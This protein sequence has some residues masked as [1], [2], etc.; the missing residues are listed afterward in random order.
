M[1]PDGNT[2]N[3]FK[4]NMMFRKLFLT[5]VLPFFAHCPPPL[6]HPWCSELCFCLRGISES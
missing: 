1:F 6:C 3:K 2:R 4:I 5:M